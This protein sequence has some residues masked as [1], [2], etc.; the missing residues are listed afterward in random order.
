[1]G[2]MIF[3]ILLFISAVVL[4]SSCSKDS[5]TPPVVNA[6]KVD[7]T[8]VQIDVTTPDRAIKSY[9]ALRDA[10]RAQQVELYRQ[11][12][13]GYR[14]NETRLASVVDSVVGASIARREAVLETFS[15]DIV[16][17]KVES[18]SRAVIVAVIKNS[19][20]I[21]TGGEMSTFIEQRRRDGER[22][23]YVLEKSNDGW[24]VAEIWAWETYPKP[25]WYKKVPVDR[26]PYV[27][28]LTSDG[29]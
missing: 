19:T 26:K 7:D 16:D 17:V 25:D 22:Y 27:G 24:R 2:C 14:A 3:K 18:E 21:P 4:L 13:P 6:A 1:M 28:W 12:L 8:A 23:K 15:R 29:R 10:I 5:P 11:A 9:W 20:P